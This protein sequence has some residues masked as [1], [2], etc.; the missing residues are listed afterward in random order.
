MTIRYKKMESSP[1]CGWGIIEDTFIDEDAPNTPVGQVTANFQLIHVKQQVTDERKHGLL[2]LSIPEKPA[3]AG[4]ISRISIGLTKHGGATPDTDEVIYVAKTEAGPWYR[5]TASWNSRIAYSSI[6]GSGETIADWTCS[7]KPTDAESV[8]ALDSACVALIAG[9]RI[10]DTDAN[11]MIPFDIINTSFEGNKDF[12]WGNVYTLFMGWVGGGASSKEAEFFSVHSTYK[13]GRAGPKVTIYYELQPPDVDPATDSDVKSF[14]AEELKLIVNPLMKYQP[15][16]LLRLRPDTEKQDG[17]E[18]YMIS[19]YD[20]AVRKLLG[21]E[22]AYCFNEYY[23][24]FDVNGQGLIVDT[25]ATLTWD[26]VTKDIVFDTPWWM[27]L[28]PAPVAITGM[29]VCNIVGGFAEDAGIV[30]NYAPHQ[31]EAALTFGKFPRLRTYR[32]IVTTV[33]EEGVVMQISDKPMSHIIAVRDVA[34]HGKKFDVHLYFES[35]RSNALRNVNDPNL[36][37]PVEPILDRLHFLTAQTVLV[38]AGTEATF[39]PTINV[40]EKGRLLITVNSITPTGANTPWMQIN[41]KLDGDDVSCRVYFINGPGTYYSG[42]SFDDVT[43]FGY[44]DLDD[45]VYNL[46]QPWIDA[47]RTDLYVDEILHVAISAESASDIPSKPVV[48]FADAFYESGDPQLSFPVAAIPAGYTG[49]V[50]VTVK[51]SVD[52][53]IDM[54]RIV[55]EAGM[56]IDDTVMPMDRKW[57][58]RLWRRQSNTPLERPLRSNEISIDTRVEGPV[59]PLLPVFNRNIDVGVVGDLVR[60]GVAFKR[61]PLDITHVDLSFFDDD[62]GRPV[63]RRFTINELNE[64]ISGNYE[65]VATFIYQRTGDFPTRY[66]YYSEPKGFAWPWEIADYGGVL[67]VTITPRPVE[68]VIEASPSI[69]RIGEEVTMSLRKS[70][71][72]SS[73]TDIVEYRISERDQDFTT[74]DPA[75]EGRLTIFEPEAANTPVTN[76]TKTHVFTKDELGSAGFPKI[77]RIRGYIRDDEETQEDSGTAESGTS[78]TLSDTDKSWTADQ[79]KDMLVRI[80][81]GTG[82]GQERRIYTNT[83]NTLGVYVDWDDIPSSDS[84]YEIVSFDNTDEV[85][86]EIIVNDNVPVDIRDSLSPYTV[87][88]VAGLKRSRDSVVQRISNNGHALIDQGFAGLTLRLR[89]KIGGENLLSDVDALQLLQDAQTLLYFDVPEASSLGKRRR[90]KGRLTGDISLPHDGT[91]TVAWDADFFVE[92]EL[93]TDEDGMVVLHLVCGDDLPKGRLGFMVDSGAA[94]VYD[95]DSLVPKGTGIRIIDALTGETWDPTSIIPLGEWQDPE[96][97]MEGEFKE[98]IHKAF[99]VGSGVGSPF[100]GDGRFDVYIKIDADREFYI[101]ATYQGGAVTERYRPCTDQLI[102]IRGLKTEAP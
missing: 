58:Y 78:N 45:I 37:G 33:T 77:V 9:G 8:E 100:D 85:V 3:N 1:N 57:Y 18:K 101:M 14:L 5:S 84:E 87:I 62:S 68:A 83:T 36:T 17:F 50:A 95:T 80:I 35:P 102:P 67:D 59:A 15:T 22:G 72:G 11:E 20:D 91:K 61:P 75:G 81:D 4:P 90:V 65:A 25:S 99:E 66:R 82:A 42:Q 34:D 96:S 19:V 44:G 76:P 60:I 28:A 10:A 63:Y 79:F 97:P 43:S 21:G 23:Y 16:P 46:T 12:D 39:T 94:D 2:L 70:T 74:E 51:D 98:T 69:T 73:D 52:Q 86:T 27:G 48:L 40:T 71:P 93:V 89:G 64:V 54:H 49:P 6:T 38:S 24:H 56:D 32:D 31:M 92:D 29:V 53:D 13:E 55:Q 47:V 7:P 26:N 88:T 41:G 30:D